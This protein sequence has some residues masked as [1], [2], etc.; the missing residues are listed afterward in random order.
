MRERYRL[1][2]E[3]TPFEQ[4]GWNVQRDI[5]LKEQDHKCARCHLDTWQAKPLPLEVDHI[6]GDGANNVRSNL[7]ALCP[8]C[9]SQTKTWRGRNMGNGRK[10]VSDEDLS[11][12]IA[13]KDGNIRQALLSVGLA[14][15]GGN[16][17]RARRLAP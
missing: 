9:H 14:A 5:V 11:A 13:A 15:K 16:Y 7:E 1:W 6:D 4:M 8:N 17:T 2:R 12:A 3:N 10:K